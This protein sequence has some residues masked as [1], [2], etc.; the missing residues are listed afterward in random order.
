VKNLRVTRVDGSG[1]AAEVEI[2]GVRARLVSGSTLRAVVTAERGD[3]SLMS[4]RFTVS[5]A[6]GGFRI[7]G[8]G[9][10]H[11]VGLCQVGAMARARRGD[12]AGAILGHY[13]PGAK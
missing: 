9:Y 3:R 13:Y 12:T 10:G 4:T 6:A 5:P 11:G 7:V 2:T 8:T 1:R